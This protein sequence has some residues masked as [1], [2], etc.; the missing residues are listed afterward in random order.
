ME[1]AM[2]SFYGEYSS[3]IVWSADNGQSMHGW[4]CVSAGCDIYGIIIHRRDTRRGVERGTSPTVSPATLEKVPFFPTS[5]P[6]N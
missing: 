2:D 6:C 4:N 5:C 3:L 1:T